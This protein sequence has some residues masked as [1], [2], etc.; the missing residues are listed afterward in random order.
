[1]SV[2]KQFVIG[3]SILVTAPFLFTFNMINNKELSY[4]KYSFLAPLWFGFWN[5]ISF[6]LASHLKLSLKKRLLLISAISYLFII[7]YSFISW[8]DFL[9][10]K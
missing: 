6:Y 10:W 4:Y 5:I 1:M 9:C 7:V 8:N 3:S 2:L